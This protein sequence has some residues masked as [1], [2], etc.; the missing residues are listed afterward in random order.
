MFGDGVRGVRDEEV[1]LGEL[2]DAES[3][4][5]L[6]GLLRDTKVAMPTCKHLELNVR[7][8]SEETT[9]GFDLYGRNK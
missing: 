7:A 2:G 9:R 3:M 8:I 6:H 1:T 5:D 4:R